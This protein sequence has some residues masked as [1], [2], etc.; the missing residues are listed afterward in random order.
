MQEVFCIDI[1]PAEQRKAIVREAKIAAANSFEVVAIEWL[2]KQK[3][4]S[5]IHDKALYLLAVPFL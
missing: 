2:S 4:A 3:Y 1:D 5:A